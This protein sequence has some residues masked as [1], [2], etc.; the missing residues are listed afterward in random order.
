MVFGYHSW[1][2]N[3]A[4]LAIKLPSEL[5]RLIEDAAAHSPPPSTVSN[6]VRTTLAAAAREQLRDRS[7][8]AAKAPTGRTDP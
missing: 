3:D 1:S 6:W 4:I 5:K 8:H 2:E 7:N